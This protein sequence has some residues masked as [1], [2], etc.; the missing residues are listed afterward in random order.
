MT[1]PD[2]TAPSGTQADVLRVLIAGAGVAGLE[3]AFALQDLAADRVRVTMLSPADEFVY[4]PMSVVE[5]FSREGARHYPL[6]R[7]ASDAGVELVGAALA[8][9]EPDRRLVRTSDGKEIGYDALLVCLGATLH[10][11]FDHAT[12]VN[13]ARMDELLHG[14]VQDIEGGYV[15]RLAIV[16]PAP[17]P[18]PMPAYELALMTSER[19]W[20]MQTELQVTVLTPEDSPLSLFGRE[21]SLELSRL[22][23]ERHVDVI[24]SAYCE[25]P[26]PGT[27][28]IH[29]GDRSLEFDRV[30]AMPALRGPAVDGLPQDGGGFIPVDEYG[31]VRDVDHVWAAGDATDF[32]IKFG[33]VAAQL[34]D[35]A[36]RS[37]AASIGACS[38]PEPFEPV[39][40]GVLL[41]GASPLRL[42]ARPAGGHARESELTKL[43]RGAQP[44]KITAK[45]LTPH[46]DL[47][48]S[49]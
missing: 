19:A 3:A 37:I 6:T 28:R 38:E 17:M 34:A 31:R 24:T 16:V 25:V 20:D 11:Q 26:Q 21:A 23:A 36:A 33:G 4:R 45:Y 5:P 27:V 42:R 35:T 1:E 14:L 22:L 13:D 40:E 8:S 2:E 7:L 18:W 39:V 41:T 12:T 44:P 9:V 47:A 48:P 29:P 10:E 49:A 30:V 32:P 43:E 46:L 15:K